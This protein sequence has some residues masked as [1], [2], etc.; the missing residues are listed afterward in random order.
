MESEQEELKN[1]I[2]YYCMESQI[3]YKQ[4]INEVMAPFLRLKDYGMPVS[5]A[6]ECFKKFINR[7]APCIFMDPVLTNQASRT[8]TGL[9]KILKLMIR[10]FLP[11][12]DMFFQSYH[13]APEYFSN[14]WLLTIFAVKIENLQLV[15]SLW[16]ELARVDDPFYMILLCIAL[17][18]LNK[19]EILMQDCTS[20]LVFLGS[21]AITDSSTLEAILEKSRYYKSSLPQSV[22]FWLQAVNVF[23]LRNI[24]EKL[25]IISGCLYL[26]ILPDEFFINLYPEILIRVPGWADIPYVVVD[27]RLKKEQDIG[28]LPNT[29]LFPLEDL[30]NSEKISQFTERFIGLKGYS[31][32]IILSDRKIDDRNPV[33]LIIDNFLRH[34]FPFVSIVKGGFSS[35]HKYATDKML[36]IKNHQEELCRSCVESKGFLR[37][38]SNYM[39]NR[40]L[41]DR[42]DSS[43]QI[44][45]EIFVSYKNWASD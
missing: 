44:A 21:I 27:C 40:K 3:R 19:E 35:C 15:Y 41:S 1:M 20:C 10:Y 22:V 16:G 32:F 14:S 5:V 6:Y 26:Q 8:L 43:P 25:E 4:G 11:E 23:D 29:A 30:P 38:I 28:Y 42:K 45:E 18:D 39:R 17:L 36:K 37:K 33:T 12:L 31:H 24:D 9:F 2:R 34:G 7:C 13:I